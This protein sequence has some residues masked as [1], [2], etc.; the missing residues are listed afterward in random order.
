MAH[1][2][3]FD[4]DDPVLRQLREICPALPSAD[5]KVSHGR[6]AFFTRE[7]D[8]ARH[9]NVVGTHH[10]GAS[11]AQAQAAVAAVASMHLKHEP[12]SELLEQL[13]GDGDI[14]AVSLSAIPGSQEFTPG[15]RR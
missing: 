7:S 4:P 11:T 13:E 10:V 1:A 6:P 2:L 3:Q 9:P 15:T 12:S 14:L 5:E 8:L